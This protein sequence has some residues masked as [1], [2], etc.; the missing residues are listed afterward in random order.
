MVV[1]TPDS[2]QRSGTR[3]VDGDWYCTCRNQPGWWRQWSPWVC[4]A[5][6]GLLGQRTA[7]PY[8]C[9]SGHPDPKTRQTM[10]WSM[11]DP[12]MFT[13]SIIFTHGTPLLN[14][15]KPGHISGDRLKNDSPQIKSY[16]QKRSHLLLC[17]DFLNWEVQLLYDPQD[18]F[19]Q[20]IIK[21][22]AQRPQGS[23]LGFKPTVEKP[24]VLQQRKFWVIDSK[25]H[26]INQHCMWRTNL[27]WTD[28]VSINGSI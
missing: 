5:G 23:I 27:S 20:F 25:E 21:Q 13:I 14:R 18:G 11:R 8:C 28:Y 1:V 12:H 10:Y 2:T 15:L 17:V 19:H 4:W 7:E 9:W 6:G 22:A 3:L 24:S 26:F 16:Y